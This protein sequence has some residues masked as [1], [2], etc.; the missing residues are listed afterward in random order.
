M[1]FLVSRDNSKQI[2]TLTQENTI[3]EQEQTPSSNGEI[4][5]D[6]FQENLDELVIEEKLNENF[7]YNDL[8]I[9]RDNISNF[10]IPYDESASASFFDKI[11]QVDNAL[12]QTLGRLQIPVDNFQISSTF[13]KMKEK[14]YF[15]FQ[16]INLTLPTN[17]NSTTL[18]KALEEQL[19]LWA[20]DAKITF[21]SKN[22]LLSIFVNNECTHE[23]FLL[24]GSH[25]EKAKMSI[26]IDDLGVSPTALYAFLELDFPVS[27]SILPRNKYAQLYGTVGHFAKREIFL[28]Q[29]MEAENKIFS[30]PEGLAITDTQ[31]E[32][33]KK[34]KEN[35]AK[36]PY[37]TALNNHTGSAFTANEAAVT[38][39]LVA[40]KE[41]SPT[42]HVLDSVTTGKSQLKLL[43]KNYFTHTAYRDVFIDNIQNE[44][45][46]IKQLDLALE[47]A[48]KD[49][50]KHIIAIGHPHTATLKA[51]KNWK[52]YKDENI[53]I[54]H[55]F[56]KI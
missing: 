38:N 22:N 31:E 18:N 16:K 30:V 9:F 12:L 33:K 11:K 24:I 41:I 52:S 46:I 17:I 39:F 55:V 13:I 3:Q 48:L 7:A 34:L 2:E 1:L 8:Y 56:T 37:V 19:D 28:H 50:S 47:K 43:S 14:N 45:E 27:F 40:L 25:T 21:S 26:V 29:P 10:S 49:P 20:H 32:I 15:L 36:I 4:Q 44:K 53:E 51:L 54:V 23:I 6:I 42:I 5:E 35:L